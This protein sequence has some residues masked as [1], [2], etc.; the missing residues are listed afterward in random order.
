MH[1][2]ESGICRAG[3]WTAVVAR[4]KYLSRT[5]IFALAT[6]LLKSNIVFSSCVQ[7]D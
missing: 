4:A 6:W 1:S 2:D 5:S 3:V 7:S